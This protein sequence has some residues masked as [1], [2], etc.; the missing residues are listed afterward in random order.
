MTSTGTG[1][2]RRPG[3]TDVARLAGV[4]QKTVSRVFNNEPKVLPETRGRGL[5]PAQQLG[6]RP[7]GAAR[8]LLTGRTHRIG[9]VSLGTAHFGPSSLLVALEREARSI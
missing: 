8:A 3:G 9:V 1:R 6:Y 4:S 2:G 7:N 5:P